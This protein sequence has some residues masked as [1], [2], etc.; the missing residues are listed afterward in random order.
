MQQAD[1]AIIGYGFAG[2]MVLANLVRQAM[3]ACRIAIIDD[4][5]HAARGTAYGT[6][7]AEHVLNVRAGNMGAFAGD[8]GGFQ[9]WR[10]TNGDAGTAYDFAPRM[11]YGDYLE[12]IQNDTRALAQQKHIALQYI[13]ASVQ[14]MAAHDG[15]VTLTLSHGATLSASRVVVATGNVF[16]TPADAAIDRAPWFADIPALIA[17]APQ[18]V[19]LIGSGLTAMDTI[20]S[21]LQGGYQGEI[22]CISRH[23]WLPQPHVPPAPAAAINVDALMHGT[24]SQRLRTLRRMIAHAESWHQVI[25]GLRPHTVALWRSL[26]L[27]EQQRFMA[28]LFTLW[29]IHRHRID[30]ALYQRLTQAPNMRIMQASFLRRDDAGV[31]V[32]TTHGEQHIAAGM[33]FDCRGPSYRA[34]PAFLAQAADD[35]LIT[36]HGLAG[37]CEVGEAYRISTAAPIYAIGTPLIGERL[38]TTAVPELRVQAHAVAT[39]LLS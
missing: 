35:G 16:S 17:R 31:V 14:H 5:P 30:A 28:R 3:G 4:T 2:G 29:N 9:H 23:G 34:L 24:L 15:T 26:S 13:A 10:T 25:D 7:Y 11:R 21:L 20:I 19:A 6:R 12:T 32:K 18:R 8:V 37:V 38:E 36:R 39:V 33:V 27:A 22:C 1:I